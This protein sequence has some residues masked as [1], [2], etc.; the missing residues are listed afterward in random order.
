MNRLDIRDLWI[1]Q[2][3][4]QTAVFVMCSA[5]Y[6][7]KYADELPDKSVAYCFSPTEKCASGGKSKIMLVDF[8][9]DRSTSADEGTVLNAGSEPDPPTFRVSEPNPIFQEMLLLC[10]CQH[11]SNHLII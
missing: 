8:R 6:Q 9:S 3:L 2:L 7:S 10:V 5:F 11:L 1:F 4:L